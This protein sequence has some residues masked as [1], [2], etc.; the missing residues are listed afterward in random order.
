MGTPIVS[1]RTDVPAAVNRG[2][3]SET[4]AS[5]RAGCTVCGSQDTETLCSCHGRRCTDHDAHP[6][7]Q[8]A[9]ECRS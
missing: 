6:I 3:H 1:P 9:D 5:A 2:W 8:E 4:T 7:E